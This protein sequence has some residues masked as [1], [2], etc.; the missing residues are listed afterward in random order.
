MDSKKILEARKAVRLA[1]KE[2][3]ES[4]KNLREYYHDRG[5]D[6]YWD[7]EWNEIDHDIDAGGS[8]VESR[9]SMKEGQM[10]LAQAR[11]LARSG[12]GGRSAKGV[13]FEAHDPASLQQGIALMKAQLRDMQ[14]NPDRYI[15]A[16]ESGFVVAGFGGDL[17][18]VE[19][20]ETIMTGEVP[21]GMTAE[22]AFKEVVKYMQQVI[23][24]AQ[25]AALPGNKTTLPA[26]ATKYLESKKRR[27]RSSSN[28]NIPF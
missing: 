18:G 17:Y 20:P 8:I 16:P 26:R 1:K 14:A 2:L 19:V 7:E 28:R 11:Q 3:L 9:K 15:Q 24:E 27:M 21:P 4:K 22:D 10:T 12:R 13:S 5:E 25:K 23:A 6:E